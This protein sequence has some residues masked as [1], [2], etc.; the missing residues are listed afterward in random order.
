[1]RQRLAEKGNSSLRASRHTETH[2]NSIWLHS[3]Q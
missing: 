3:I 1:L 2:L